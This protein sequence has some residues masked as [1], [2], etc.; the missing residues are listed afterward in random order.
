MVSNI[1]YYYANTN[2]TSS[3]MNG[4]S[5]EHQEEKKKDVPSENSLSSS[6]L[7]ESSSN[8]KIRIKKEQTEND[9][10]TNIA[11]SEREDKPS[12]KSAAS[13]MSSNT[14]NI[15]TSQND[16]DSNS[17][18]SFVHF[19]IQDEDELSKLINEAV[20]KVVNRIASSRI[21][22]KIDTVNKDKE[23]G[24]NHHENNKE[25][26]QPSTLLSP[27]QVIHEESEW[28]MMEEDQKEIMIA[29]AMNHLGLS[30]SNANKSSC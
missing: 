3:I 20:E 13:S 5:V 16:N 10:V 22:H 18:S 14:T 19:N 24:Q 25:E 23:D 2:Y 6:S 27:P 4:I 30:L 17:S 29:E 7:G 28:S 11:T 1:D 8:P 21:N 12:T 26:S 9:N 15:T